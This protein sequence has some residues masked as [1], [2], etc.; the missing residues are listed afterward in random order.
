MEVAVVP[1]AVDAPSAVDEIPTA[2][3]KSFLALALGPH[4]NES[5]RSLRA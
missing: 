1:T 3:P 2:V 4:A 5:P